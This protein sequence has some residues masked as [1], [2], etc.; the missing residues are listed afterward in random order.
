MSEQSKTPRT[1]KA[2]KADRESCEM[3]REHGE[4]SAFRS[5][6]Y[7]FART[8]ECELAGLQAMTCPNCATL[9]LRD[10]EGAALRAR[11]AALEGA[12]KQLPRF[13]VPS[14]KDNPEFNRGWVAAVEKL[15][16]AL[17][18]APA[19]QPAAP[20]VVC[21]KAAECDGENCSAIHREPHEYRSLCSE[22]VGSCPVCVP[23]KGGA[24]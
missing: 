14:I 21:P 10:E 8:L 4:P 15:H 22:S 3:S 24:E 2:E 9:A 13:T 6:G 1:D 5:A 17:A 20:L 11:V 23:A 19:E 16:S 12:I 7:D 18:P